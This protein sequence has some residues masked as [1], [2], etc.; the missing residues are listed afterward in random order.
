MAKKRKSRK[1][2]KSSISKSKKKGF[3]TNWKGTLLTIAIA[4][5]L[6]FFIGYSIYLIWDNPKYEDFC[7][8][9]NY[10]EINN[11]EQCEANGGMWVADEYQGKAT[12]PRVV[13]SAA[14]GWCDNTYKCRNEY[15]DAREK[16]SQ[17]VFIVAVI[18]GLI[19][20]ILGV[21]LGNA[22]VS[23]GIMLGGLISIVWGVLH[24]WEFASD[25]LRVTILGIS[26]VVLIYIA[27]KK[28]T[29]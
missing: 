25:W 26:L 28:F 7:K 2:S 8:T 6:A 29:E 12:Y 17:K 19:A 14:N 21:I 11:S 1:S 18:S 3:M 4:V 5:V 16:F 9:T 22:I 10:F 24:Y 13:G 15:D 20:V 27:Y 23:S